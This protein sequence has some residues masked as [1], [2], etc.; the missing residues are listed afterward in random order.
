MGGI[1]IT[2]TT[3]Q[4]ISLKASVNITN[5]TPYS[6]RVPWISIHVLCNGSLVGE[7][8]AENLDIKTGNNTNLVV[9]ATWNPTLGGDDGVTKGRNLLSQYLSGFNTSI[10]LRTH[11]GSIPSQP[12]LGEALSKL[13]ITVSAPR[14]RL[15]G[16]DED[17]QSHFIRGATMH[18]LSSK[19]TFTLVSPLQRNTIYIDRINATALYNHTEPVGRIEYDLPFA[20]PPGESVTPRLPVEWSV[21]SGGYEKL[22]E[23]LGGRLKLDAKAVVEV[24]LGAWTETLWFHGRGIG[25]S[26]RL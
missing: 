2:D 1:E 20:A 3:P 17:E 25:A 21:D 5:P 26:I 9:S 10:T 8:R 13:N 14:L 15:P 22:Q 4:S 6:A 7:A 11:R 18:I 19:A 16:K 23:A 12:L 24:R